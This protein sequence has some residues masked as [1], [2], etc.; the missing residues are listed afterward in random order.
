MSFITLWPILHQLKYEFVSNIKFFC[1]FSDK[2]NNVIIVM[3][4][5]KVFTFGSN[6]YGVLGLGHNNTVKEPEIVNELCDQQIIDISYGKYHVLAL[7]K[8]GKCYSWGYNNYGQLG[9]GTQTDDNKPKLINALLNEIVVQIACANCHSFVLT[10][11]GDLFGFGYNGEGRIGCGNNTNQLKPIK[12]YGFNNEKIVSIACGTGHSLVLTDVRHV[13]S[14]GFNGSG[15]LGLGDTTHQNTPQKILLNNNQIIKSICCGYAHS[16]LLTID[17]DIYA[18]GWNNCGQIGNGNNTNQLNPVKI[19]VSQKFNEIIS[20]HL[21]GT[22]ISVAKAQNGYCYVWGQCEN[23]SFSI[24]KKTEIKSTHEIFS[25]YSKIKITPKPIYLY[26]TLSDEFSTRNRALENML[27]IFNNPKY[28]DLSFKIEDKHIYVQKFILQ[29]NCKHFEKKFTESTRAIRE[30]TENKSK[31]NVIEITEY[32]Y[33]AYHALLKYLY[34]DYIDIN[35][36]KA[37]DLLVLANDYKEEELKLK[38]VDIIKNN[39][40]LENICYLYCS[41]IEY[42]L[43]DLEDFCFNFAVTKMKQIVIT[44]GFRQMDQKSMSKLMEK[45]AKNDMFK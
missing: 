39:I 32:S 5:D 14:W 11:S 34:T 38:C 12:T 22:N 26:S 24:P 37:I 40:T 25:K 7:T 3:K 36:E 41:S 27:K 4:N 42:N 28:S 8:S 33:D 16:L 6:E 30:S 2:G 17:G 20:S 29:T 44:E 35:A 15:Q 31:E 23:E 18:F 13:Y 45:A 21:V 9:N 10:K 19:T 43:S 1:V